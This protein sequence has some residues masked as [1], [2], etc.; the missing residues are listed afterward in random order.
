[1]HRRPKNSGLLRKILLLIDLLKDLPFTVNLWKV[2]NLYF[3]MSRTRYPEFASTGAVPQE[4]VQ[5]FLELGRKLRI[6]IDEVP[7]KQVAL[8][9]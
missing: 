3:E 2:E 9:S 6:R 1:L 5:D 7:S 4:W 8:A